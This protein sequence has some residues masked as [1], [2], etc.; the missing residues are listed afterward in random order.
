M[1]YVAASL[2][3]VVSTIAH[4]ADHDIDSVCRSLPQTQ[5]LKALCTEPLQTSSRQLERSYWTAL[6]NVTTSQSY[7][8]LRQER[9]TWQR[10]SEAC[11]KRSSNADEMGEC[12]SRA[13]LR[14]GGAL[15]SRFGE[16]DEDTLDRDELLESAQKNLSALDTELRKEIAQC[17]KEAAA[18]PENRKRV[19][20]AAARAISQDCYERAYRYMAF[21]TSVQDESA[22]YLFKAASQGPEAIKQ[23]T[24]QR[25]GVQSTL[26]FVLEERASRN[27]R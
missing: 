12:L 14:F 7:R 2:L 6:G 22:L 1:R 23:A 16:E 10:D 26:P 15:E 4:A 3:S 19:P 21:S 18:K 25:Y 17:R 11:G 20:L 5:P 27:L 13:I 24:E 9:E 8:E